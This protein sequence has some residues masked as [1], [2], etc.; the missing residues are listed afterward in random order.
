MKSAAVGGNP[1]L[2]AS[3]ACGPFLPGAGAMSRRLAFGPWA[4]R[5][6]LKR[7]R[8]RLVIRMTSRAEVAVA[9]LS[10]GQ[11]AATFFGG[12]PR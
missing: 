7:N 10:V 1:P 9:G 11:V 4:S 2:M 8:R 3:D 6:D 5:R 12:L